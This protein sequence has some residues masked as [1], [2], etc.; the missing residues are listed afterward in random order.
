MTNWSTST[1]RV[2][3]QM[4]SRRGT[5]PRIMVRRIDALLR[6]KNDFL[7]FLRC[8]EAKRD[9]VSA[10]DCSEI[11]RTTTARPCAIFGACE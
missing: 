11:I 3:V 9:K 6:E 4:H 5:V 8:P 7:K 1:D 2:M 10:G